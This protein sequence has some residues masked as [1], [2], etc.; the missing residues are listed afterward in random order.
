MNQITDRLAVRLSEEAQKTIA[1]F[2]DLASE[3]WEMTLYSDGS[4]WT[5]RQVLAH[6]LSS[7]LSFHRLIDNVAGGGQGA[8]E[9][10]DINAYNEKEVAKIAEISITELLEKWAAARRQTVELV[11]RLTDSDLTRQG[12]HPFLGIVSLEDMI[13]LIYRHN[14]IHLRDIRRMDM[15][16]ESKRV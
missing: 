5:V 16:H 11:N 6:F 4:Q 13:K 12:R 2:Q 10:F 14:Q 15:G 3:H 1:F 8:P 7:E 9:G